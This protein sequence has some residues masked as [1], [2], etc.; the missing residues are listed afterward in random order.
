MTAREINEALKDPVSAII[1]AIKVTLEKT[2]PELASD[3]MDRG[4][5]LTGGGS[6]LSGFERLVSRETDMPVH[7]TE[8]PLLS[9]VKGTGKVLEELETLRKVVLTS[10]RV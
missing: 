5:V 10:R 6:L 1:D 7:M 9:V 2:P 8:E 4:I 3:I